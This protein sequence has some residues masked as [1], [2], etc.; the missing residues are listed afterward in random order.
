[1]HRDFKPSNV[2]LPT[3]GEAKVAD[4]GL[5]RGVAGS[6]REST[7]P[8]SQ[9]ATPSFELASNGLSDAVTRQDE[10]VGT[11][12]FMAPEQFEHGEVDAGADQYSFCASLYS[13]LWGRYPYDAQ[14]FFGIRNAVLGGA[15]VMP[16]KDD[17]PTWLRDA[18]LRGMSRD[19]DQRFE[20]MDGLL[21]ALAGPKRR[22][23]RW[24]LAGASAVAVVGVAAI[25]TTARPCD[26]ETAWAH[27]YSAQTAQSVAAGIAS[28]GRDYAGDVAARVDD[29][30]ANYGTQWSDAYRQSCTSIAAGPPSRCDDGLPAATSNERRVAAGQA[31]ARAAVAGPARAPTCRVTARPR[32][33]PP[34]P[35]DAG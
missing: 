15:V 7:A 26:A 24:F 4:F 1:M 28:V 8:I 16:P 12:M 9:S 17:V 34:R 19:A 21:D 6:S 20:D 5:A 18:V 33:L 11:P 22:W 31:P 29:A 32:R 30:V 25:P 35:R 27:V 23:G 3:D 14:G 2:L 13:A 10:V